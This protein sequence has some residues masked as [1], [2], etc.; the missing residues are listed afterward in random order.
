MGFSS[1]T[2]FS[3]YELGK[4]HNDSFELKV[5]YQLQVLRIVVNWRDCKIH[6]N[7]LGVQ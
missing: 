1:W 4:D 7:S 6:D 3:L 2:F 5:D